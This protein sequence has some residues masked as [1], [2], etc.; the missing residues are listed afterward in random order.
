MYEKKERIM[1]EVD[2]L[3]E[4]QDLLKRVIAGMQ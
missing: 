3:K 4:N 1:D 2:L